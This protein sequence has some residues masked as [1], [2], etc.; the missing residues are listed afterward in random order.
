MRATLGVAPLALV[1]W[2]C[3][4]PAVAGG[5]TGETETLR[6]QVEE[7]TRTVDRLNKTVE[8]LERQL[9]DRAQVKDGA[10]LATPTPAPEA[11]AAVPSAAKP[12]ERWHGL[13][14]GMTVH[15]VEALLGRPDRTLDLSPNTLWYYT[16]PDVGSGSVVFANDGTVSDWQP[17]PFST[18]W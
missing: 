14:T 12:Q 3:L 18:W 10:P 5:Q 8:G 1:A 4:A 11:R 9:G 15:Q 13:A 7:L 17:P 16:Y 6:Q 2:L